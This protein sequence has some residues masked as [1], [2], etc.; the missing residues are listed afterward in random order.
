MR[1]KPQTTPFTL[2]GVAQKVWVSEL[3]IPVTWE[4]ESESV[5]CMALT[6][7]FGEGLKCLPKANHRLSIWLLK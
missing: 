6:T 7:M 5:H 2:P 3:V 4:D 1:L